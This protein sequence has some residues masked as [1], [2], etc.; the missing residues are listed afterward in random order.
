MTPASFP[1]HKICSLPVKT[2][3]P[4]RYNPRSID[5]ASLAGLERSLERF[6]VVQP[7]VF[8]ERSGN[9][10]GGH[11]RLKILKK[12]GVTETTVIVVDL[13]E[14]E[15]KALNI[16]LNSPHLSGAFSG[17]LIELLDELQKADAQLFAE[18]RLDALLGSVD[19]RPEKNI[20]DAPALPKTPHSQTG[21][22]YILGR[23][24]LL[25]G[26]SLLPAS[27]QALLGNELCDVL[28][29]DPPY[30][31]AYE[32]SRGATI[33][34][35]DLEDGEFLA[36]L[37]T[38][39]YRSA[40]ALKKG[41]VAYVAH[42]DTE[43]LNFRAA[44]KAASF[45]L[46]GCLVWLKNSPVLGHADYQWRHEPIL[47]GWKNDGSHTWFGDRKQTTAIELAAGSSVETIGDTLV[48]VTLGDE[49]LTIEGEKM[50]LTQ[51]PGSVFRVAKPARNAEHPTMKPVELIRRML[52]NSAQPGFRIL[53]P[54]GGSGST[55]M[56]AE[57]L[58]LCARL[59]ELDPA[60]CDV[61]V[62]R[63]ESYSGQKAERI[64]G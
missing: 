11:Q 14:T 29:T 58:H 40:Q 38:A 25:C 61:I 18:L 49:T 59:I 51:S 55:L 17:D 15:E 10:V 3:R 63:W 56:A 34:N 27:Y 46:A 19:A 36:F 7:I 42:A 37:T 57:D 26:D 52:K 4:A 53:D 64:R 47:Y 1:A 50:E 32:G 33:K 24:R 31:V 9:V 39:F 2:L 45:H 12:R 8:N 60:Y 21:D 20:E 13:D 16:A 23:H 22:L 35:D 48:Q 44:F 62:A 43:G 41:A 30:N 54:F 6:G 5:Q 28:W